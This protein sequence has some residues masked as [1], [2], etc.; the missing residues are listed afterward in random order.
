MLGEC[1][2]DGVGHDPVAEVVGVD[3]I[4]MDQ[5]GRVPVGMVDIA[6]EAVLATRDLLGEQG[7]ERE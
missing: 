7:E 4:V 5:P 1:P 2:K 3:A 6:E